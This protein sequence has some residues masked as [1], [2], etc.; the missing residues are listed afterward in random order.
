[1][2]QK[3]CY[4]F[5]NRSIAFPVHAALTGK[6]FFIVNTTL[7]LVLVNAHLIQWHKKLRRHYD[8]IEVKLGNEHVKCLHY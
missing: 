3:N 4:F 5:C 6:D 1:M 8:V 2:L 7:K